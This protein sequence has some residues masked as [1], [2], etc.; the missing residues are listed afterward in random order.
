MHPLL[1]QMALHSCLAPQRCT[2][3]AGYWC[4]QVITDEVATTA[5]CPLGERGWTVQEMTVTDTIHVAGV[6]IMAMVMQM[7]VGRQIKLVV[8]VEVEAALLQH[9]LLQHPLPHPLL[10]PFR[11]EPP[12]V[13]HAVSM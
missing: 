1:V 3:L 7:R 13:P 10:Q 11:P 12:S 9:L 2:V 8:H 5:S 4:P 6:L